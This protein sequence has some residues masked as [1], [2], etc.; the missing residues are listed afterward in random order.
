[1]VS[2]RPSEVLITFGWVEGLGA[3]R[4]KVLEA[5]PSEVII[6]VGWVKGW[7]QGCTKWC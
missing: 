4:V 3:G 5:G 7:V 1:M 6:T 2:T